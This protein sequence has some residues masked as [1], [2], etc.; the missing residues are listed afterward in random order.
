[1]GGGA[2]GATAFAFGANRRGSRPGSGTCDSGSLVGPASGGTA[3]G[4][5]S[6]EAAA[7]PAP[8]SVAAARHARSHPAGGFRGRSP[9]PPA[10]GQR[11]DIDR[12][13]ERIGR[14]DR[15]Q[16]NLRTASEGQRHRQSERGADVGLVGRNIIAAGGP[17][18]H[19]GAS[20]VVAPM[21][22]LPSLIVNG[23]CAEATDNAPAGA[24]ARRAVAASY[25]RSPLR[26]RWRGSRPRTHADR[27]RRPWR[28]PAL[29]CR[30][31]KAPRSAPMRC[32]PDSRA[33]P[34]STPGPPAS[35]A[36]DS[37][38]HGHR[39]RRTERAHSTQCHWRS[40]WHRC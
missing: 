34:A 31:R 2:R 22:I 38:K 30:F 28:I 29:P 36:R 14:T 12:A 7:T 3:D 24:P 39:R 17:R 25:H 9:S 18:A 27:A 35:P 11:G 33:S 16:L 1:M 4:C 20:S 10:R 19:T 40:A 21:R 32:G 15:E 6:S 5:V 13:T 23:I 26:Y 8:A 37:A